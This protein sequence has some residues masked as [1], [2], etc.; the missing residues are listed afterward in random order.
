MNHGN[1]LGRGYQP[2]EASGIEPTEEIET[3]PEELLEDIQSEGKSLRIVDLQSHNMN[4]KE[5][6]KHITSK[7][8]K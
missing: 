5:A 6:Q 1:G 3:E 8:T 7:Q 4:G 2:K